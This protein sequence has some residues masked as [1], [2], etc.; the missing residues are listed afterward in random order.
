MTTISRTVIGMVLSVFLLSLFFPATVLAVEARLKAYCGMLFDEGTGVADLDKV[1]SRMRVKK[2]LRSDWARDKRKLDLLLKNAGHHQG[3]CGGPEGF[4]ELEHR[5]K[6]Y[7]SEFNS[8]S[9]KKKRKQILKDIQKAERLI[10]IHHLGLVNTN[11]DASKIIKQ[12]QALQADWKSKLRK[13]DARNLKK[14]LDKIEAVAKNAK[15]IVKRTTKDYQ[16]LD[17]HA[18]TMIGLFEDEIKKMK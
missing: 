12:A 9:T 3:T 17:G 7:G 6:L 4:E 2:K 10:A 16:T 11:K 18:N 15:K 8:A 1:A 13:K 5:I 14:V